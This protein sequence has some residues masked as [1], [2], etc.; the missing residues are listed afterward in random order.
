MKRNTAEWLFR[1]P[2]KIRLATFGISRHKKFDK[3]N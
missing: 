1:K 3:L 2:S